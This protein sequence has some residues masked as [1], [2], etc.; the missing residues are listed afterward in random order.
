VQSYKELKSAYFTL[1]SNLPEGVTDIGMHPSLNPVW[2]ICTW[3]HM[4]L[5]DS[6]FKEHIKN[7]NIILA[8]C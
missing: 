7:E 6:D 3:E 2:R 5:M 8:T 1:V 4:L